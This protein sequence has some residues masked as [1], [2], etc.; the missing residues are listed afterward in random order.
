M[1]ISEIGN[2]SILKT[3]FANKVMSDTS[4]EVLKNFKNLELRETPLFKY[5]ADS[6]SHVQGIKMN[7]GGNTIFRS[8]QI[9]DQTYTSLITRNKK[10]TNFI[11]DDTFA[12]KIFPALKKGNV[13]NF[14]LQGEKI[15]GK[16]TK[17]LTCAFKEKDGNRYVGGD[18]TLDSDDLKSIIKQ[19]KEK[20]IQMHNLTK[21]Y[22]NKAIE[23]LKNNKV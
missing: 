18:A 5:L 4:Y 9:N 20:E 16:I 12:E 14:H 3:Q 11:I 7:N 6:N 23:F 13:R 22:I 19:A 8:G 10:S 15:N 21:V 2:G 1:K 17:L